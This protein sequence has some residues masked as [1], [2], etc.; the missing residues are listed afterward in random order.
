MIEEITDRNLIEKFFEIFF[1]Q[2]KSQNNPF[3]HF[4]GYFD[5]D[6][7]IGLISVSKIY[8]RVEVNYIA[9]ENKCRNKGIGKKL[10]DYGT[11]G[12]K[13]ISLEVSTENSGA[14]K[15]YLKNGFVKKAV[16]KKYYGN[17]DGYLMVK[18]VR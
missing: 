6:I 7:L 3:E 14:I 13:N 17:Y 15:F 10:L 11:K 1:P 2:Y 4:F 12:F 9:V 5:N 16:R 8:E 18:E